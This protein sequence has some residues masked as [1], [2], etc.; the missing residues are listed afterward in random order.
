MSRVLLEKIELIE[1]EKVK[2]ISISEAFSYL[3]DKK[4]KSM[5]R[6]GKTNVCAFDKNS[7]NFIKF[8]FSGIGESIETLQQ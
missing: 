1:G 5:F 7:S 3:G 8:V 6:A 2:E 4:A